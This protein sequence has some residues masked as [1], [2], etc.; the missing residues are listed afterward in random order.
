MNVCQNNIFWIA[1]LFVSKPDMMVHNCEP[2]YHEQILLCYLEGQGHNE[3][4]SN[5]NMTVS[6]TFL[7]LCN[8]T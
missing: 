3:S 1:E 4:A 5:Q 8:Q 7:S 2:E 6:T